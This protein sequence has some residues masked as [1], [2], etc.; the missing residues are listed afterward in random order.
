[1]QDFFMQKDIL[2]YFLW[3]GNKF[4]KDCTIRPLGHVLAPRKTLGMLSMEVPR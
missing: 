4:R 3:G 2:G 1:M